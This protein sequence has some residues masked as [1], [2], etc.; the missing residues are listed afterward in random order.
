MSSVFTSAVT[1]LLASNRA[2]LLLMIYDEFVQNLE[3][4]T[5]PTTLL[6]RYC[7]RMICFK[8]ST[9]QLIF[10]DITNSKGTVALMPNLASY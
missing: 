3:K 10:T 2:L 7:A 4:P 9:A 6:Q 8:R 1:L 5:V